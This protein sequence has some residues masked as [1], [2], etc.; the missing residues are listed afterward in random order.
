MDMPRPTTK[1]S[2]ANRRL[3]EPFRYAVSAIEAGIDFIQIREK[4]LDARSLFSLA[5]A[6]RDAEIGRAH[7]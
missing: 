4:D 6:I 5:C 7:V 2:S 3:G 1:H